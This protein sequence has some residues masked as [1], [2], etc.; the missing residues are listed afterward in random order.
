MV[1]VNDLGKVSEEKKEGSLGKGSK[2]GK[3]EEN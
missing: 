2:A 1:G 3:G